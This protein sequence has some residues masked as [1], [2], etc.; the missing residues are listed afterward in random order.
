MIGDII[1][2]GASLL[3]GVMGSNEAAKN[4]K[5]QKEFAQN[6]VQWRVEDAKA[7]GIHP[8]AALGATGASYTPVSSGF[9]DSVA[10]AGA[11]IGQGVKSSHQAK[12]NAKKDSAQAALI[13]STI[14]TNQAQA[15]LHRAQALNQTAQA[16]NTAIGAKGGLNSTEPKPMYIRVVDPRDP[17]K[18]VKWVLNPEIASDFGENFAPSILA[19]PGSK[20]GLIA[21]TPGNIRKGARVKVKKSTKQPETW[22]DYLTPSWSYT[23]EK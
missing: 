9:G 23:Q 22:W 1:S 2:A 13:Q 17:K 4:R 18:E 6:S 15:D 10:Q 21:R 5:M 19:E 16:R 12:G 20:P 7:A 11:A 8:L 14:N 3:G